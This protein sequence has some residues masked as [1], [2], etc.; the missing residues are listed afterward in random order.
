[1][2]HGMP[3]AVIESISHIKLR[4]LS[5]SVKGVSVRRVDNEA[6][7]DFLPREISPYVQPRDHKKFSGLESTAAPRPNQRSLPAY[8]VSWHSCHD[9][10]GNSEP[11]KLIEWRSRLC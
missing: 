8:S 5:F 10:K 11:V 7:L 9:K 1:M 4:N 6:Q 3:F 2:A